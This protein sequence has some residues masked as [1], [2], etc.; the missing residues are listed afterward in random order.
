MNQDLYNDSV[1]ARAFIDTVAPMTDLR[2][3]YENGSVTFVKQ[4]DWLIDKGYKHVRRTRALGFAYINSLIELPPSERD[5]AVATALSLLETTPAILDGAGIEKLVYEDYYDVLKE[6]VEKVLNG[7]TEA[8]LLETFQNPEYSNSIVLYLRLLTSAQIRL[9][10]DNYEGF[11]VHPDTKEPMDVDS[12]TANI[13]QAMGKEADNVE[14]DALSNALKINLDLA[15]L[16]GA[17]GDGHVD[18]IQFRNDLDVSKL[19]L[20]LLYRPGHYDI[21]VKDSP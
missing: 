12:F 17:S 21:L 9:K 6:L 15:Y 7:L 8:A 10:R 16:N 5:I 4:I 11:L 14:I 20:V 1:P 18:F 3:E 2:T 19:P 13:V